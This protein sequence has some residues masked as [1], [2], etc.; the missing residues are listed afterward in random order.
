MSGY[1]QFI[2]RVGLTCAMLAIMVA[3]GSLYSKALAQSTDQ[4]EPT[5]GADCNAPGH[6]PEDG[7]QEDAPNAV[8]EVVAGWLQSL[9]Q[10]QSS[11]RKAIEDAEPAHPDGDHLD[12]PPKMAPPISDQT[13]DREG[14]VPKVSTGPRP[15]I[16]IARSDSRHEDDFA[17]F[18]GPVFGG[19]VVG[20]IEKKPRTIT[21]ITQ[22]PPQETPVTAVVANWSGKNT[23]RAVSRVIAEER[24]ELVPVKVDGLVR[25]EVDTPIDRVEVADPQV[26]DIRVTSPTQF[27]IVGKN[28]GSTRLLLHMQNE[29]RSFLIF[30]E[31]NL[32]VLEEMIR[33]ISPMSNV[34][35]HSI[36]GTIAITGQVADAQSATRIMELAKAYQGGEI[37]N[38]L[39]VAGNQQ[40]LLRVVV[41]EVNKSSLRALG[42]NWAIGGSKLSRDFF[43]ANNLGQLNPTGFASSGL[44]DLTRGQLTYSVAPNTN[45]ILTNLTFGFPRAELQFFV[46]A[47]RENG[48]ARVLAEPNLVAISGQ[49]ATFLAGGEVPIPVTQG[50]ATSGAIVIEYKEFGIRLAFTPTVL[51]QQ[52][53]RIHVMTEISDAIPDSRQVANLPVFTFTTRRVESTIECGNNQTFAIAGLLNERV[54]AIAS[55]IPGLGDLPVLGALFSSVDYQSEKTELVVLVTPILVEPLEPD[56]VPAPPGTLITRPNDFELFGLQMLEGRARASEPSDFPDEAEEAEELEAGQEQP[57]VS[58]EP[59]PRGLRVAGPRGFEVS[60]PSLTYEPTLE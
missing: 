37:V 19:P 23:Q 21:T 28:T 6:N 22:E 40:T 18:G 26:A 60:D 31:P 34:G 52:R 24:P 41:A 15:A 57:W 25:I 56:Q 11:D 30:V 12:S 14:E 39:S 10:E 45:G 55:K 17:D 47:L 59:D 1:P 53:I 54:S 27:T 29:I 2:G 5:S 35:V 50:G 4:G 51:G 8:A 36:N 44:A 38:H 48:L 33:S 46:N 32:V 9:E 43:L 42:V 13:E 20:G 16:E 3:G 7:A 49:T 58:V